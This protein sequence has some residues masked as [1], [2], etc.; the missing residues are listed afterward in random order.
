VSGGD[1]TIGGSGRNNGG[2]GVALF[3]EHMEQLSVL[4]N[5]ETVQ[6][7][8]TDGVVDNQGVIISR[9]GV[10]NGNGGDIM[11]HGKRNNGEDFTVSGHVEFAGDGTGVTG[12]FAGE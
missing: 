11:F 8:S 12:N 9:G 7:N 10:H 1:G 3:P 2:Q 4:L 5:S 6:G